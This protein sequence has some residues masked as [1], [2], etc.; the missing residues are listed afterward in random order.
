MKK[1]RTLI[2]L[3]ALAPM[4]AACAPAPEDVCQ[5]VVDL[6]K[7]ELGE[8]VDAMPEDEITKIKDNCVKEAEKEKEMKGALEYKKQAKCV[9]AAESL[10]DLKTCEE[11]EKK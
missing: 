9:M 3:A 2:A 4:L 11:D 10:D 5:H 7:K 8:Q 1:F 6:M